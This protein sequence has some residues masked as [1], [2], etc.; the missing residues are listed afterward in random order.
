MMRFGPGIASATLFRRSHVERRGGFQDRSFGEAAHYLLTLSLDGS[1]RY[2][3]GEAV[4]FNRGLGQSF[5]DEP[6]LSDKFID[7]AAT[8]AHIFEQFVLQTATHDLK[9]NI[10]CRRL[11][12]SAWFHA[13]SELYQAAE[14]RR[15]WQC[16]RKASYWRPGRFKYYRWMMRALLAMYRIRNSSPPGPGRERWTNGLTVRCSAD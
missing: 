5:G 6:H 16:F 13:G 4:V 9:Q 8:L 12:A 10:A 15:A 2:A 1:W 11:L 14:P 7:A 3:P